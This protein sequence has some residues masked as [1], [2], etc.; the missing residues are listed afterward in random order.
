MK[1]FS[2]FTGLN[3]D[4]S[5]IKVRLVIFDLSLFLSNGKIQRRQI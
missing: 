2:N 1:D 4:T 5:E 3:M